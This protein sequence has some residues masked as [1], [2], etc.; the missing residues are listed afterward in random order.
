MLLPKIH[1]RVALAID[2]GKMAAAK[3][4]VPGEKTKGQDEAAM[5]LSVW[6][7]TMLRL[8]NGPHQWQ[9]YPLLNI[10]DCRLREPDAVR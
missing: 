5:I 2:L 8:R 7:V 6:P 1:A 4:T 3:L 9:N 10:Q